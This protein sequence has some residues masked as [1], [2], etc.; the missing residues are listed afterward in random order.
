MIIDSHCHLNYL[1]LD[2]ISLGKV[3]DNAKEAGIEKIVSIAV[4]WDEIADIERI[5]ENFDNVVYHSV[6]VHPS[7]LDSYQPSVDDIIA[8]SQHKK[9][10][11][12]GETG[13]DY[14]Y[15]GE[16]TKKAQKIKFV[17]HMQ[18][19]NDVKK[20]VIIHTRSAKQDTLDILKSENVEGCGGILHCFTED[21]DMAKKAL[22][23]GMY[24]SFSGILTFKNARDIQETA[25]KLP[26]DRILIETDAPYLT[27]VPLR[28]K[29]NYPEYV[30][31]VAQFLADLKGF[32]YDEVA[33]QTYKNTC[34]VFKL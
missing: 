15:N 26:L 12:I 11:A 13:L 1:K 5:T 9:C 32:S 27:P 19:A 4:A 21:Y 6:G 22:D 34:E 31:Y 16:E 23:M 7:E 3:I 2:D 14:Y 17:N 28:G 10:V 25:K 33:K 20:P 8:R 24:I 29:P 18:A 30:K